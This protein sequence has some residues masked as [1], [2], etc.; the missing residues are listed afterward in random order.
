[1]KTV[2]ITLYTFDDLADDVQ[3]EIIESERWN[4][5]ESC[6]DA[7]GTD[8]RASLKEFE[9]IFNVTCRDWSV[10]YSAF[11]YRFRIEK[12]EAFEWCRTDNSEY[13]YIKLSSLKGKLLMRYLQNKILP[14]ITKGK[15]Y[16]KL[17]G[18]Y[19]NAKHIKRY[20]KVLQ[21]CSC[22][23]TGT[24]YDHFLL[25]PILEYLEKPDA[26]TTYRHLI[27]LCLNKFF[28]TWHKEYEYWT[29]DENAIREELHNNQYEDR[30][31]Y[32]DGTVSNIPVSECA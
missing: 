22:P 14:Y 18:V 9:E 29:D 7:Y 4:I 30:L 15:Y 20:S 25:D 32:K 17:K 16:G 28:D 31:Y 27:D 19:P 5:M 8:Y 12:E 6:M 1:V 11:F 13:D 24:I 10:D 26:S 21:E 23:M 2:N 3:K